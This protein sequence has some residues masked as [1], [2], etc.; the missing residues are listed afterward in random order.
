MTVQSLIELLSKLPQ[1]ARV[2]AWDADSEEYED[3]TGV[4][5]DDDGNELSIQTDDP[6]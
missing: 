4:V 6:R 3:V 5:W 1:T 2:T